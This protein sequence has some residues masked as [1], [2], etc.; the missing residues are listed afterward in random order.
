MKERDAARS[1]I[2]RISSLLVLCSLAVAVA[3]V[4]HAQS[5]RRVPKPSAPPKQSEPE[6]PPDSAGASKQGK[7]ERGKIPVIVAADSGDLYGTY[8]FESQVVNGCLQRLGEAAGIQPINGS[9][10]NRKEARDRAKSSQDTHVVWLELRVD[11]FNSRPRVGRMDPND[12]VVEYIL[13]TPGTGKVKSQG[14]VYLRNVARTGN[15][16]IGL[17]TPGGGAAVDYLSRRAGRETAERVMEAIGVV[18]PPGRLD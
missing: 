12:M 15:V 16:G 11:G 2:A 10:M 17:P 9:E 8:H 7:T 14:R 4:V 3:V 6:P 13:F 18:S 1:I 5:G